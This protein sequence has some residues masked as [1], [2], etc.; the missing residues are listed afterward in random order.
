MLDSSFNLYPYHREDIQ[1]ISKKITVDE[2]I[3]GLSDGDL[4]FSRS[5]SFFGSLIQISG[6]CIWNHVAMYC[7]GNWCES[8]NGPILKDEIKPGVASWDIKYG[9]RKVIVPGTAVTFGVAKLSGLTL[10][11]RRKLVDF[12]KKEEGK[13]Y[14]S[15]YWILFSSWFDGFKSIKNL[16]CY[17]GPGDP[18]V[19]E[20]QTSVLSSVNNKDNHREYFCSQFMVEAM[21]CSGIMYKKIKENNLWTEIPSSEWTVAD[22]ANTEHRLNRFLR[23]GGKYQNIQFYYVNNPI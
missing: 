1:P 11:Q 15:S 12:F 23:E 5:D 16:I 7:D 9:L 20:E 19:Y 6:H 14:T 8:T 10:E 2:F 3:N 22:L 18:S 4:I 17:P 13:K 21:K